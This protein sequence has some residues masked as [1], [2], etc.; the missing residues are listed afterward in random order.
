MV[1]VSDG[2]Y[3]IGDTKVLIF[4]RILRNHVM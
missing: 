4:V 1:K 3:R 2:K